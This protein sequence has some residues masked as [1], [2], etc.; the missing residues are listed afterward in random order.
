LGRGGEFVVFRGALVL[1]RDA[2]LGLG[3]PVGGGGCGGGGGGAAR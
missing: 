2:L 1:A 3:G